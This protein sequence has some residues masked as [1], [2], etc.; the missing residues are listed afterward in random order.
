MEPHVSPRKPAVA[1][2][3]YPGRP[4]DLRTQVMDLLSRVNEED[5]PAD[6]QGRVFG[7]MVPHAGY[8]YSGQVA[9]HGYKLLSGCDI[10]TA[11]VISPSHQEYFP[12]AA[13]FPG[14][15]Y[16]TPLGSIL[17]DREMVEA[18]S[19]AGELVRA[20][21]RGH[22]L[23]PSR[24]GEHALEVQLPFLQCVLPEVKI[25]P[26]VMG[27]QNW[28]ICNALGSALGPVLRR[29]GVVVIASSDLSHFHSSEESDRLDGRFLQVLERMDPQALF[30]AVQ[31][32]NCEACGMG[33]VVSAMI[34]GLTAGATRCRVITSCNSGDVSGDRHRVVGY[35]AAAFF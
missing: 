25:L 13:V 20:S 12:F 5:L 4:K 32:G 34:A 15:A 31:K 8:I 11:I 14:D 30:E 17:V 22:A 10:G 24:Q 23:K 28:P 33:P 1:G 16:E 9:A 29:P 21:D 35:A 2:A 6:I 3:F 26:V 27:D 19:T 7:L 18:V